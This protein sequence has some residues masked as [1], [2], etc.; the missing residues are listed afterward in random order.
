M[1]GAERTAERVEER[2]KWGP[3]RALLSSLQGLSSTGLFPVET[4]PGWSRRGGRVREDA[5]S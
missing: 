2:E 5:M 4:W 1:V 3:Q